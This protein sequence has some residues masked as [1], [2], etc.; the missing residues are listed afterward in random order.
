MTFQFTAIQMHFSCENVCFDLERSSG[1]R[2]RTGR[3]PLYRFLFSTSSTSWSVLK[4]PRTAR[5]RL[6]MVSSE[7]STSSRPPTTTGSLLGLTCTR[8]NTHTSTLQISSVCVCVH[9]ELRTLAVPSVRR[10][11]CTS[12]GCCDTSRARD[13]GRNRSGRT[14]WW[15]EADRWVW[16]PVQR[17]DKNLITNTNQVWWA[18]LASQTKL[19]SVVKKN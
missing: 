18:L 12:A 8:A 10:S 6:L 16:L 3:D 2:K 14:R 5:I 19:Y 17:H 15:E 13:R 9:D 1:W 7:Q 4:S 11:R